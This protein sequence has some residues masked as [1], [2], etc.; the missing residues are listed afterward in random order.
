MYSNY[1]GRPCTETIR[2]IKHHIRYEIRSDINRNFV[3]TR[4][5]DVIVGSWVRSVDR[6]GEALE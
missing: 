2:D 1:F 3:S 4:A 5:G 6:V